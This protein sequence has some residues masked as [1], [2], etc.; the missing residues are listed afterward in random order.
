MIGYH[1]TPLEKWDVIQ[2][3]GLHL[4]PVRQHE[5]DRFRRS[6]PALPDEAIWVWREPL[7][8]E[9]AFITALNLASMHGS[10]EIALLRVQYDSWAA[11]SHAC[12]EHPD[13]TV[14]LRCNFGAG[15]LV[16]PM[17]PIELILADVPANRV[18]KIWQC[19]LLDAMKGRHT[20]EECA[21]E[22]SALAE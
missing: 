7:T 17:L 6:L 4:A 14:K 22:F 2:R 10:Y 8:D 1:Y 11:A 3:E 9:Q 13:D 12:K 21:D 16:T 15:S 18:E 19:N 5:L 20:A